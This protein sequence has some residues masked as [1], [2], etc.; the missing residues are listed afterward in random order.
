[1]RRPKRP[2]CRRLHRLRRPL[3][4]GSRQR[5]PWRRRRPRLWLL[6]PG[7]ASC[8]CPG[9]RTRSGR[10]RRSAGSRSRARARSQFTAR[11]L[12]DRGEGRQGPHR[13]MRQQSLR[14]FGRQEIEPERRTGSDQ[15]EARQGPNGRGRILDPNSGWTYDSTIAMKGTDRLRVQGCAF[16]G[17]FCGGQT[18][19]ARELESGFDVRTRQGPA[20]RAPL[21]AAISL[22]MA[23]TEPLAHVTALTS[24]VPR[25]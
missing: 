21:F 15:H 2:C 18:W 20:I 6:P 8:P 12:A 5:P 22:R 9:P 10:R 19:T 24:R 11:H 1:M 13:A 14:L 17:M 4:S 3:R 23:I 16:G 25:S 7:A